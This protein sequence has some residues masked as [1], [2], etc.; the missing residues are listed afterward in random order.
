MRRY[1]R[2]GHGNLLPLYPHHLF[3]VKSLPYC[4]CGWWKVKKRLSGCYCLRGRITDR[5]IISKTALSQCGFFF[6]VERIQEEIIIIFLV[7][8]FDA[9]EPP[10]NREIHIILTGP[11]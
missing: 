4:Q 8:A 3:V 6:T 10:S 1:D 7:G 2:T 11:P 5:Q 9:A